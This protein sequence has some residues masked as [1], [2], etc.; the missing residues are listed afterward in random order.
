MNIAIVLAGGI[1]ARVG[2]KIPKQFIEILG[3]P[4]IIYT[5]E[6]FQKHS[7]IDVIEVVC[8]ED[9]ISALRGMID[10]YKLSKVRWVIKGGE[11]FQL[12]VINGLR[13]L[14]EDAENDDI[15]L[16]HYGASPFVSNEIISDAIKVCRKKGNCTS[17]TPCYLLMGNNDDGTKSTKWIDRDALMQLN[18]PQCFKYGY[19]MQLYREAEEKGVLDKVEPHTTSLMYEMG[20]TIYFS[21]GNQTNIKITTKEDLDL[22]EGYVLRQKYYQE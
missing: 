4:I 7:E 3:K 16:I 18:S 15:V 13:N 1:G 20:Q 22:F 6:K 19:V 11:T 21:K 8:V 17:A 2:D 12:S 5:L 10:E 14:S 9:Y